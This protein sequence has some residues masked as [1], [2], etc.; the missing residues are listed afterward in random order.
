VKTKIEAILINNRIFSTFPVVDIQRTTYRDKNV[1]VL[2]ENHY[3]I[4]NILFL[5]D[6][7]LWC[8]SFAMIWFCN[9]LGL[10]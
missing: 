5:I 8:H 3:V 6:Q 2:R 1:P 7:W 10:Q 9:D 4:L